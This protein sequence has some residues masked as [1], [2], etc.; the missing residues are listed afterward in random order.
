MSIIGFWFSDLLCS[1]C[2]WIDWFQLYVYI[3]ITVKY[4]YNWN[5][6]H[7]VYLNIIIA[8][9][10]RDVRMRCA[11]Q[12]WQGSRCWETVLS[13]SP[14]WLRSWGMSC[15]MHLDCNWSYFNDIMIT[16]LVF[17]CW[18]QKIFDLKEKKKK[19]K[20]IY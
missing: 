14:H 5:N 7:H 17:L 4:G 1:N 8:E 9:W 3:C 19:K 10:D 16:Y 6:C 20:L 18:S 2:K 15:E 11:G 13:D 12:G